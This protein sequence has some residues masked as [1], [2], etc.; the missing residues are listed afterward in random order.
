MVD[1]HVS[2]KFQGS[3]VKKYI[4]IAGPL[5]SGWSNEIKCQ[6]ASTG[7]IFDFATCHQASFSRG[8]IYET[9]V[10]WSDLPDK[11]GGVLTRNTPAGRI[12]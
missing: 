3:N 8:Q 4:P 5:G 2:I 7:S 1:G 12:G 11:G 10:S 6:V 9:K